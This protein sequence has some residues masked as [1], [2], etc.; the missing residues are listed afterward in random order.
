MHI[1]K[2]SQCVSTTTPSK[3]LEVAGSQAGNF[4]VDPDVATGPVLNTTASNVTITS[5][6][7]SVII[8]LG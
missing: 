6:G 2:S 8:Q 3:K 5:A 4:T 1:K 7:G